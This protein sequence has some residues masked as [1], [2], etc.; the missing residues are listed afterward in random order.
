MGQMLD[1]NPLCV[2]QHVKTKRPAAVVDSLP[3]IRGKCA[4]ANSQIGRQHSVDLQAC[5]Q[6]NLAHQ[7]IF[8]RFPLVLLIPFLLPR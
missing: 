7:S 5:P 3:A 8:V 6:M 2:K 1:L 4:A